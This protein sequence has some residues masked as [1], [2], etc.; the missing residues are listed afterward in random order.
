MAKVLDTKG[1][2]ALIW[3]C[4]FLAFCGFAILLG[5]VAAL[6]QNCGSGSPDLVTTAGTVGY[7]APLRQVLPMFVWLV[8]L[9]AILTNSI[10]KSR[11]ALI[12]LL[13][14]V[15]V[16]LMDTANTY[17]YYNSVG[18]LSKHQSKR[19]ETTAAAPAGVAT[20]TT[21]G[22]AAAT[23]S[24][25]YRP[26]TSEDV[27]A[28][29]VDCTHP[30]AL[31]FTHHKGSNNPQDVPPSDTS[32]GI[33]LNALKASAGG[34]AVAQAHLAREQVS[35]NHFDTDAVLSVWALIH[36]NEALRHEAGERLLRHAARIGDLRSVGLQD[37]AAS[38]AAAEG[39]T[40]CRAW[41]GVT[42]AQADAALKLNC[43]LNTIERTRFSCPYEDKA[44]RHLCQGPRAAVARAH[45]G[46]ALVCRLQRWMTDADEKFAFFLE[47]LSAALADLDQFRADWEEEY[48]AVLEG[49]R[50]LA[51]G[52]RV[53]ATSASSSICRDQASAGG[54]P[55]PAGAAVG[56]MRYEDVGVAV[57]HVREP[58]HYYCTFSHAEPGCDVVVT[59]AEGQRYEVESRYSQFVNLWSRPVWVRLDLGPLAAALNRLDAGREAGTEWAAASLVDTGPLLRL[60]LGGRKLTKAQRYG[61]PPARPHYRSGLSPAAFE[62]IVLS[63][64]RHGLEGVH[65][66]VGGWSWSELHE[67]AARVDWAAWEAAL[68]AALRSGV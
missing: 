6:Q 66:K 57:A 8:I 29:I 48:A 64:F 37:A 36:P 10:H 2:T 40:V 52:V 42:P 24:R 9:I 1:H 3:I 41:D 21:T 47:H 45:G 39:T 22:A 30:T 44:R 56:V 54:S 19:Y 7:L 43:W 14:A 61:H 68:P 59:L 58:L 11:S 16:L 18:G 55:A 26:F 17:L 34:A 50:A 60:D 25:T 13:A 65:P 49:W 51:P 27:G 5:G 46:A 15:L 23:P 33:V 38:A 4:H 53:S 67:L 20:T 28:V 62:A 31:T 63:Y 35:V 32:T 12:G